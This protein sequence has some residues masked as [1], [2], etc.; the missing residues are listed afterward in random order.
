MRLPLP[1]YIPFDGLPVCP[2]PYRGH[3]STRRSKIP[4][5][6]V[7]RIRCAKASRYGWQGS[8]PRR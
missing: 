8:H 6:T 4:R 1:L 3:L 7:R 5:P 2:F